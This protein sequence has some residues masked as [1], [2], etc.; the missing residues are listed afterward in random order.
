MRHRCEASNHLYQIAVPILYERIT[1]SA[2][3]RS[4]LHDINVAP[5]LQTCSTPRNLLRHTKDV[6]IV[7]KLYYSPS[8]RCTHRSESD[9]TESDEDDHPSDFSR[10]ATQLIPLLEGCQDN[11][12]RC[13]TWV[14]CS[15]VSIKTD[16]ID[17]PWV[18]AFLQR[19][20]AIPA[21][22]RKSNNSLIPC[23]SLRPVPAVKIG[24][25]NVVSSCHPSHVSESC[26]GVDCGHGTI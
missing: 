17:G 21:T 7:S 4:M 1:V 9:T 26:C 13:F 18:P 24:T 19:S 11:S 14:M 16:V 15:D 10:L 22:F 6:E 23:A 2:K 12:L 5:L 3:D 25:A 20:W 8:D